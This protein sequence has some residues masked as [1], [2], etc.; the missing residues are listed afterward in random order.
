MDVSGVQFVD[1]V[2]EQDVQYIYAI[3]SDKMYIKESYSPNFQTVTL[4]HYNNLTLHSYGIARRFLTLL[5]DNATHQSLT[6][7]DLVRGAYPTEIDQLLWAKTKAQLT[8]FSVANFLDN[9][10]YFLTFDALTGDLV[11]NYYQGYMFTFSVKNPLPKLPSHVTVN[12]SNTQNQNLVLECEVRAFNDSSI[13]KAP[14]SPPLNPYHDL[15]SINL[16]D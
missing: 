2:E 9:G 8:V 14:Q 16:S 5:F 7:Y 6:V 11:L 3:F 10:N 13:V 1:G 15:L 12:I 4:H